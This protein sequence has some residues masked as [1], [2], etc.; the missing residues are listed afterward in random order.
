ME[1]DNRDLIFDCGSYHFRAGNAGD[2]S[3]IIKFRTVV[4]RPKA[5]TFSSDEFLG[6]EAIAKRGILK[7]NFPAENHP[8]K[9]T[10]WNDILLL[11]KHAFYNEIHA[12][13]K[14]C[15]VLMSDRLPIN[16]L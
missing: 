1:A 16:L 8:I 11:Y 10:D 5:H 14:Q 13:P 2:D 9:D 12:D 3:P 15:R 6:D 4:G 7:L